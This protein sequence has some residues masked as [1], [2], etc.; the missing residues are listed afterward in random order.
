MSIWQ[1]KMIGLQEK[2]KIHFKL[3]QSCSDGVAHS[4]ISA[5]LIVQTTLLPHFSQHPDREQP[6]Y[7]NFILLIHGEQAVSD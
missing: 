3:Y 5:T 1:T 2:H 6:N 4:E 7:G